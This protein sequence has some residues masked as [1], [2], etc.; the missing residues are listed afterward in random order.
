MIFIHREAGEELQ[1]AE[2]KLAMH[3]EML[4]KDEEITSLRSSLGSVSTEREQLAGEV[5][6]LK[7][8]VVQM[9]QA[10]DALEARMEEERKSAMEELSRGKEAALEQ[11]RE[12]LKT[13][14]SMEVAREL[15]R[16]E[17]Q[18]SRRLKEVEEEGRLGKEELELRLASQT[19]RDDTRLAELVGEVQK[20]SA[21][22]KET[23]A[24]MILLQ[25][26]MKD[27][28]ASKEKN[29][30]KLKDEINKVVQEKEKEVKSALEAMTKLEA[31]VASEKKKLR[32]QSLN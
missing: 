2:V 21:K 11:E 6:A 20:A 16:A 23:K 15:S 25:E 1:M 32:L 3:K 17:E 26:Q 5:D 9:G 13:E 10:Q 29:I 8:E 24:E 27:G 31:D 28:L 19:P 22:E 18:W 12:R 14:H 4:G 7:L 30:E